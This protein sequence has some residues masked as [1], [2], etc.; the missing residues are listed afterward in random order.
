M[1]D[2]VMEEDQTCIEEVVKDLVEEA[3]NELGEG[4]VEA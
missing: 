3:M 4:L 2:G 1:S